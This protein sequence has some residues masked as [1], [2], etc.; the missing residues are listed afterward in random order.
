MNLLRNP[1]YE[2]SIL[3]LQTRKY[4]D[5]FHPK[6]WFADVTLNYFDNNYL[7]FAPNRF[8]AS[9]VAMYD[10]DATGEAKRILGTQEKLKSGFLLDASIGKVIYLPQ[11]RSMNI[12]LSFSNILN[13]TSM[14][15]GGFQQGRMP[16]LDETSLDLENLNR[17]PNKYYYAWGFNMFL[18][19]GFRF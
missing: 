7:D 14:V 17:F 11:R 5:Y 8:T 10:A 1:L 13:N 19:L 6:M 3:H 15:T 4:L 12:N 9:N 18:N 16:M 2:Y